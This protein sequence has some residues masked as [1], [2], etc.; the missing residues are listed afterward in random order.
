VPPKR[1]RRHQRSPA[2]LMS[3]CY[4]YG[5]RTAQSGYSILVFRTEN[6]LYKNWKKN[7]RI[8]FTSLCF[9]FQDWHLIH[10]KL[11]FK[12]LRHR[13]ATVSPHLEK[14][15]RA[16]ALQ[17]WSPKFKPQSYPPKKKKGS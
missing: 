13:N 12:S 17:A 8:Q 16:P 14:T 1:V 11:C 5:S 15:L 10:L 4:I 3:C 6:N 2:Y 7:M 9:I